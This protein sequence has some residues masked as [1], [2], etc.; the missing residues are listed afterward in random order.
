M[1]LKLLAAFTSF[2]MMLLSGCNS[3]PVPEG[4]QTVEGKGDRGLGSLRVSGPQGVKGAVKLDQPI[5]FPVTL[6]IQGPPNGGA[7]IIAQESAAPPGC[8]LLTSFSFT[9]PLDAMGKATEKRALSYG[10]P[11]GCSIEFQV[12]VGT[13]RKTEETGISGAKADNYP[14]GIIDTLRA[15][16][17][18]TTL[19]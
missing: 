14:S 17:S 15:K 1:R 16:I 2:F 12:T 11:Q 9:V 19:K 8:A 7:Q 6:E 18:F 5:E 4:Q 3:K 10:A 13:E